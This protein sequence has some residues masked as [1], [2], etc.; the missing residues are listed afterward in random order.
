MNVLRLPRPHV[1]ARAIERGYD[2]ATIEPCFLRHIEGDYWDVDVDSP[3]YPKAREHEAL[4]TPVGGPGTEL[5]SLIKTWLRIDA[6]PNC[7]CSAH[8]RQMDEWGPDVCEQRMPEILGWL[9]RQ[10]TARKLPFSR[11][12]AEQVV[13]MAIRRARKGR[14][15]PPTGT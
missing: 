7:S 3:A 15:R 2:L 4:P 9:E 14:S 1:I 6:S 12:V 10:A 5:K 8:A 11:F 13:R